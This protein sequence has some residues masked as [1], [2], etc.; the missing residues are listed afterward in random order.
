[1]DLVVHRDI[2]DQGDQDMPHA[3]T[4]TPEEQEAIERVYAR[5]P[6]TLTPFIHL[7]FCSHSNFIIISYHVLVY[8]DKCVCSSRWRLWVLREL[9]LLRPFWHVTAM[10]N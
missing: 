3:V 8:T 4:V 6:N 7:L 1:M 9:L 10:K 5:T 2:F